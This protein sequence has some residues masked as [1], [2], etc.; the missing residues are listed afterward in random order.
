MPVSLVL[1]QRQSAQET[2]RGLRQAFGLMLY[3]D[4][5]TGKLSV[6]CKGTLA[7][8]QPAPIDG[9][10]YDTAAAVAVLETIDLS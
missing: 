9:S 2:I 10:N 1:R 5:A 8:Q 7:E 3:T 6:L 4:H